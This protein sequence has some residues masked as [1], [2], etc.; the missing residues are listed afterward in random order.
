MP[1]Y[2]TNVDYSDLIAQEAAK[3]A[4][5]NRDLLAQYESQRNAK[6]AGEGLPYARTYDYTTR[7]AGRGGGAPVAGRDRR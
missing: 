6:I 5:A 1:T 2:S 4:G 3:G 7:P